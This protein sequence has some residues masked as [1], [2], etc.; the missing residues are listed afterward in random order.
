M[1]FHGVSVAAAG[2]RVFPSLAAFCRIL[3]AQGVVVRKLKLQMQMTMVLE[4]R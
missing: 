2:A 4:T 3:R 1:D